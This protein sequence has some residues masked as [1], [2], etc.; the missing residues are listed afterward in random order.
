MELIEPCNTM[1][2]S[3]CDVPT[4]YSNKQSFYEVLCY[5]GFKINECINFLN[6]YTDD[7]KNYTD[8]EI[9]KLKE[10]VTELNSDMKNYV[11]GKI[12][13]V[14]VSISMLQ[15]NIDKIKSDVD[16]EILMLK[17]EIS[18]KISDLTELVYNLDKKVYKY[19]GEEI[20]KL[21]KFIETYYVDNIK[22]YNPVNG[23]VQ[24]ISQVF[25]SMY[26]ALRYFGITCEQF[27]EVGLTCNE[28]DSKNLTASEFDL[29]SNC[30]FFKSQMFYMFNPFTGKHE[31]YQDVIYMLA[32]LH[33]E[34][35][36][37]VQYFD[38]LELTATE[39]GSKDITAYE[40]DNNGK[41]ILSIRSV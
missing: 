9:A 37:T 29:Y 7:Y 40:F 38:G 35:P 26:D 24:P 16:K 21:Y 11:D 34:N 19:I 33:M 4:V 17:N 25:A 8:S 28:F 5:L 22:V 2:L 31:F 36:V 10:Y 20:A 41:T 27:E 6:N 12:Y 23:K 14:N 30:I 1:I 3:C 13:D 15:H 32:S 18:N 39:Y